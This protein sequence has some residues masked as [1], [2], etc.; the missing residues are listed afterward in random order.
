[1]LVEETA[2]PGVKLITLDEFEDHRGQYVETYNEAQYHE[3]GITQHFVQDDFSVSRKHVLRGLHGDDKTWKLV[4][5]PLGAFYFVV[6]NNDP[7][8]PHYKQWLHFNLT[9]RKRQQV[10]VPPMYGNGHLV[11]SD[12]CIFNYKQTTYYSSTGQFSIRYDDPEYNI[13]WPIKNPILSRRDEAGS[14]V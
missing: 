1:M 6:V 11:L 7:S 3:H 10:L 12:S 14:Y 13:W 5:C 2:L 9:D 4:S 8:S